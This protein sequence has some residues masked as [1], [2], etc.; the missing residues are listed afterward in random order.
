[1][2]IVRCMRLALSRAQC[3][4]EDIGYVSFHGTST[5]LNDA[6]VDSELGFPNVV[7]PGPDT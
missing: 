2:E 4:P 1:M 7:V 5:V 6:V 3:V